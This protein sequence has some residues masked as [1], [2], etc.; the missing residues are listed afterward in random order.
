MIQLFQFPSC[1]EVLNPS[2]FCMKVEVYLRMAKIPYQV[3]PTV[4]LKQSPTGKLPFIKDGIETIYDSSLIIAYLKKK[5]GDPLDETLNAQQRAYA[6]A[7]KSLLEDH[8]MWITFYSRWVDDAYWPTV[9]EAFFP[10]M[11]LILG[12]FVPNLIR[13][14]M[15]KKVA[16]LGLTRYT[17]EEVYAFGCNDL[18]DL[19]H[20][21]GDQPF[22]L[23][24]KPTSLD[25]CA[26]AFLA[27]IL[28]TPIESPLKQH[29]LTLPVLKRYCDNMSTLTT[30]ANFAF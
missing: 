16:A 20:L 21:L 15:I 6:A 25:A 27:N 12:C 24:N 18:T 26:Y 7:L 28:Q 11:P 30:D 19:A 17:R 1:W 14:N 23:G 5:F 10:R 4:N 22:F 8:L 3:V 2:P 9:K 13:K 29:A